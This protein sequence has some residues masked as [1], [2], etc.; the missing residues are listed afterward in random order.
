MRAA[1]AAL[2]LAAAVSSASAGDVQVDYALHLTAAD[3]NLIG[4]AL[5]Q[6][7]YVEVQ[8]LITKLKAQAKN[9]EDAALKADT[10]VK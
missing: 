3:M 6:R 8:A 2:F 7:P 4:Q 5:G 1:V 10:E 9:S